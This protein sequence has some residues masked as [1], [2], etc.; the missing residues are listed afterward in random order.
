MHA[1]R[2]LTPS[3]AQYLQVMQ[4]C[5]LPVMAAP[6]F[7]VSGPDLLVACAKAGIVGTLPTPNARST[8]ILDDWLGTVTQAL[9]DEPNAAPWALNML[10]HSSYDRFDRELEILQ[11][12]QPKIV[13]TALG[14]PKRVIP[15]VHAYGGMVVADVISPAMARKAIEAGV[16]ALILVTSG[17]GGHT[18]YYHPFAFLAEVRKFW[19]GPVG[20]AGAITSGRDIRAAQVLGA[21]FVV[22]GT[23]FIAVP[24]SLVNDEYRQLVV[25]SGMEDLVLT[26]AVSGVLA[27]WFKATLDK[28]G[29]TDEQLK[30][31]KKIDFSG[32]IIAAPKAWKEVWSAGQGVGGI[33]AVQTV[34]EVVQELAVEYR[35]CLE[36]EALEVAAL[37]ERLR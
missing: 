11:K 5:R 12:Y 15:H 31:E 36:S 35:G 25:E 21:D 24:E 30:A 34:A 33:S 7:L 10:V 27:N 32:D 13:S 18:G 28:V 26:K 3:Q 19:S 2:N 17:A 6:M 16:D 22:A 14:S 1:K 37:L 9:A 4:S 29:F 20:L 23:R 8:E